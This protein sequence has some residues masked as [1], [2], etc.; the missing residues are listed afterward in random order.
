MRTGRDRIF[1]DS[2]VLYFDYSSSGDW[3]TMPFGLLLSFGIT[4]NLFYEK[5]FDFDF[6]FAL[7]DQN[8][9][10]S[11]TSMEKAISNLENGN[12]V[13][14]LRKKQTEQYQL[15]LGYKALWQVA[16]FSYVSIITTAG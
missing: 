5:V 15:A 9:I 12:D 11:K 3:N 4:S 7:D 16:H 13:I 1:R 2:R 10:I 8:G 14:V 6:V